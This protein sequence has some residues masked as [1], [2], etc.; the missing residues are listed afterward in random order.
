MTPWDDLPRL[1]IFG[2]RAD[3]GV[4]LA[5]RLAADRGQDA[6]VLGQAVDR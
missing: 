4:Q 6:V 3:A 2:D 5:G 1:R